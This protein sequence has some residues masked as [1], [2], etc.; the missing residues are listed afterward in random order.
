MILITARKKRNSIA[1]R[2]SHLRKD[3]TKYNHYG[4]D[5]NEYCADWIKIYNDI[6]ARLALIDQEIKKIEDD[7]NF[8]TYTPPINNNTKKVPTELVKLFD[9]VEELL[10]ELTT[11]DTILSIIGDTSSKMDLATVSGGSLKHKRLFGS[12]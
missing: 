3:F 4:T 1:F 12:V 11:Y 8:T 10:T 7:D 9:K 2:L 5:N 6:S